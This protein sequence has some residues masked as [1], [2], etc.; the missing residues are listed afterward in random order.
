MKDFVIRETSAT[1]GQE[2]PDV[3]GEAGEEAPP[4]VTLTRVETFYNCKR[5]TEII[6]GLD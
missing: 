2:D 5:L 1:E 6:H 3:P 4:D